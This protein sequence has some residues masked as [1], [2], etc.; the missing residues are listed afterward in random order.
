MILGITLNMS[1]EISIR[2]QKHLESHKITIKEFA[3]SIGYSRQHISAVI[4]LR[5]NASP[6]LCK[7]IYNMINGRCIYVF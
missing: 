4:N 3:R 2:L 7:L 1:I 6:K 5:H